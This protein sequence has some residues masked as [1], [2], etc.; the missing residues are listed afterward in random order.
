MFGVFGDRFGRKNVVANTMLL[1]AV[2]TFF[3]GLIPTFATMG[4]IAT[5]LLSCCKILQGLILGAEV[6]GALTFLL[7]HIS[8]KRHGLHFGFMTASA[9]IGISFGTFVIWVLTRVLTDSEILAW[10]F[11]IPFLLGGS[12][13]FVGYY[14]RKH[15][16]E[17]PAFLGMQKV[18]AKLTIKL[19]KKHLW[20]AINVVLVL[21]FPICFVVFFIFLPTYLHN[22]YGF[23]FSDIYLAMTC[24]YIWSSSLIPVFGWISDYTGRKL[25]LIVAS[26]VMIIFSFPIFALL[27]A[28]SCLALFS[29]VFFGRTVIAA[30]SASYSVL[31]PQAFPASI[32]CTGSAF[33]YNIAYMIAALMLLL[34]NYIYGILK[35]PIYITWIFILLA[36]ITIIGTLVLEIDKDD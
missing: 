21:S 11:R 25:L 23:I 18:G 9:G 31:I 4:L 19:I 17:T 20:P 15:L 5:I 14:I 36:A 22:I 26:L 28:G 12:L 2:V 10:G 8:K 6:P 13:T 35:Q 27:Q 16:P 32:R 1:M 24:A 34:V 30:L 3:M 7:E 29:F 33:S